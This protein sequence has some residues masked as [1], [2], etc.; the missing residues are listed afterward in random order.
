MILKSSYLV[1]SRHKIVFKRGEMQ[2]SPLSFEF[3]AKSPSYIAKYDTF[4]SQQQ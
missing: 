3:V 2:K 4:A 1:I